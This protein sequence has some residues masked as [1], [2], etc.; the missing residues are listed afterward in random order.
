MF[1]K[2]FIFYLILN[3]VGCVTHTQTTKSK[4]QIS[5]FFIE[6][7]TL[8]LLG[9]QYDYELTGRDVVNLDKLIRSPYM[10]NIVTVK[11]ELSANN[12]N[13]FGIYTVYIDPTHLSEKEKSELMKVYWF[14][15]ITEIS[16]NVIAMIKQT[17]PNWHENGSLLKRQYQAKGKLGKF[18]ERNQILQ[19]Y[20]F[21]KTINVNFEHTVTSN[22]MM[23]TKE[24]LSIGAAYLLLP[25]FITV[26]TPI[27]AVM[28][29]I[30]EV[31]KWG[32]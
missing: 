10:K 23:P 18:K 28:Y 5:A 30:G 13:A 7:E 25:V 21:P 15:E 14:N 8:Y 1:K 27:L 12:N 22:E 19:A 6:K 32:D 3:L 16:P 31:Q 11:T 9:E 26:F 4:E 24:I 29:S 20:T 17:K 2:L